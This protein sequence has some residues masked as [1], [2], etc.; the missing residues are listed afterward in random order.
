MTKAKITK[1]M[2]PFEMPIGDLVE[3]PNN[4]RV[5]DP[6]AV[7]RSLDRFGQRYPIVYRTQSPK[8]R[9]RKQKVVIIGNHR[10]LAARD[11]LGWDSIAAIDADDLSPDEA[12]A[13]ALAD[14]RT[15]DLAQ[16]D[17][18]ALAKELE[19]LMEIDESLVEAASYIEYDW[20]QFLAKTDIEGPEE[21]GEVD[22]DGMAFENVC[23]KCGYEFD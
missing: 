1:A 18:Q 15:S 2:V 5:G 13:L 19:E 3:N 9:A 4:P 14:N 23:P 20:V 6:A 12:R 17:A 10:L 8:P 7:A 11:E 22:I 21:F 16:Y